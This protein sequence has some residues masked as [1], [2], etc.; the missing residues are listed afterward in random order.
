MIIKLTQKVILNIFSIMKISVFIII[1]LLLALVLSVKTGF[2][3][4]SFSSFDTSLSGLYIKYDKKLVLRIDELNIK[5]KAKKKSKLDILEVLEKIDKYSKYVQTIDINKLMINDFNTSLKIINKDN[6]IDIE[7]PYIKNHEISIDNIKLDYASK[8]DFSY[9][10]Y[11]L[12]G[13]VTSSLKN[14]ILSYKVTSEKTDSI[15]SLMEFIESLGAKKKITHWI[16]KK[17]KAKSYKLEELSGKFNIKTKD[18]YLDTLQA[19]IKAEDVSIYFQKNISPIKVRDMK[20]ELKN[21][22]LYFI[23]ENGYYEDHKLLRPEIKIYNIFSKKAGINIKFDSFTYFDKSI[24]K[25]LSSYKIK[26]PISD[27]KEKINLKLTLDIPFVKPIKVSYSGNVT[28]HVAN[29]FDFLDT[30]ITSKKLNVG[31]KDGIITFK[32]SNIKFKDIFDIDIYDGDLNL[33]SKKGDF[34]SKLNF[35]KLGDKQ[36]EIIS[37]QNLDFGLSLDLNDGIDIGIPI[38]NTIFKKKKE[39]VISVKNTKNIF[40][41]SKLLQFLEID[42]SDLIIKTMDFKRFDIKADVDNLGIIGL[43]KEALNITLEEDTLKVKIKENLNLEISPKAIDIT[44]K[45]INIDL[46]RIL[47]SNDNSTEKKKFKADFVNS[48]FSYQRSSIKADKLDIKFEGTNDLEVNTTYK[49]NN[50]YLKIKDD[51]K[52]RSSYL[53]DEYIND[54]LGKEAFKNGS[55]W[56]YGDGK[57]D[58]FNVDFHF[59]NSTIKDLTLINNIMAFINAVPS[60]VTFSNPHFSSTGYK[61]KKGDISANI[62]GNM[63]YLSSINI[64]GASMNIKGS[65]TINTDTQKINL[66]LKIS[67]LN[68]LGN[69]ISNI[70]IAGYIMLGDDENFGISLKVDGDLFNPEISSSIFKDSV[71]APVN[72][73]KRVIITPFRLLK[74]VID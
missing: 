51:F 9:D 29:S 44:G 17:I 41:M 73:L 8:L 13:N 12:K 1:S 20:L 23:A 43:K 50:M 55:F 39:T 22:K 49:T 36:L 56:I 27:I 11:N 24:Q 34:S 4:R 74:K 16:Y 7:I 45:D 69:I 60:L 62:K 15:V 54:L 5:P 68:S 21:S 30:Y 46:K 42:N 70:P 19:K 53:N 71:K 33:S 61:T 37:I 67:F 14:N 28:S 6:K 63:V 3:I 2:S 65:G 48:S 40:D 66:D 35:L 47:E 10:M 52:L 31:F 58:Y 26:L 25:L 72:I 18:F 38:L 57:K 32:N 59:K 64:E